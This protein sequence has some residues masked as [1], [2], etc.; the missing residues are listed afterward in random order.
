MRRQFFANKIHRELFLLFFC[1]SVVPVL[2]ATVILSYL[3]FGIMAEQMLFPEAIAYN[4]FPAAKKVLLILFVALPIL[5]AL[6]LIL[7]YKIT[8]KIVGPFDRITREL[9]EYVEG[10]KKGHIDLRKGDKFW[11]LVNQINLLIDRLDNS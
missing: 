2:I 6:L 10:K 4:I 7:A 8:H 9:G 11:P 5:I 1:V 3:I